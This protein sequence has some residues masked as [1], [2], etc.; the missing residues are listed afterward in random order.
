MNHALIIE[1][2][3]IISSELSKQLGELGFDSFDHV[4]T[5]KDAIAVAE[6]RLPDLVLVGDRLESG[7]SIAAARNICT[8]YDVPAL[9]VTADSHEVRHRLGEGAILNG[10]FAF[11]Q[12]SEAVH[13]AQTGTQTISMH[14]HPLARLC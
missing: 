7:S 9:L 8:R 13:V 3:I 4:W 14:S 1:G 10:P 11:S 12:I 2:N 6:Q 5:E